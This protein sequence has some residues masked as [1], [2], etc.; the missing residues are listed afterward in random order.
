MKGAGMVYSAA[1]LA[2]FRLSSLPGRASEI[3]RLADHECWPFIVERGVGGNAGEIR[4]YAVP[5]HVEIA[6]A[7]KRHKEIQSA[8]ASSNTTRPAPLTTTA[9][10][11]ASAPSRRGTGG[12]SSAHSRSGQIWWHR[13]GNTQ[14]SRRRRLSGFAIVP[15]TAGSARQ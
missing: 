10:R 2:R 14:S 15:D 3:K 13:E 9:P 8:L 1:E 11:L 6:L 4:R 7:L 5:R 12:D